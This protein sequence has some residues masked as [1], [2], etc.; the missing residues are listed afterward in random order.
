MEIPRQDHF[1]GLTRTEVK[2]KHDKVNGHEMKK[3]TTFELRKALRSTVLIRRATNMHS[4]ED[5]R[6]TG[7]KYQQQK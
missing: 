4:R 1:G 3:M 7:L 2:F 5:V 6:L